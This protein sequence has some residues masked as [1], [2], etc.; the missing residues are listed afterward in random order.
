MNGTRIV[1]VNDILNEDKTEITL[2]DFKNVDT[3]ES[4]ENN[5]FLVCPKDKRKK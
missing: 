2:N 5:L 1:H 3:I 4:E